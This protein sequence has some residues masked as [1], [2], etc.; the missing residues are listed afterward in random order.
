M[1]DHFRSDPPL[2]QTEA[3]TASTAAADTGH[4]D[5]DDGRRSG[6]PEPVR[7]KPLSVILAEVG[8]DPSRTHV[9]IMD[10]IAL[11]GGRGRA[12]LILLF[13]LPNVL[14]AP[15]GLSGLLGLPLVYL[16]VQMILGRAPWLPR[17]IGA[18]AMPRPRFA[19]LVARLGPWLGRAERLLRPRWQP[20]A[21]HMAERVVG[22]LILVLS[23]VLSL[24]VPLGNVLP[25]LAICLIALG[26]MERDGV[27][28]VA[29][30]V[31]G[32]GSLVLVAGIVYALAEAAVFL[33]INAFA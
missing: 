16:S 4:E 2:P 11:L 13:A 18:R 19:Q 33:L 32:I 23:A 10:L 25:A 8:E 5:D 17:F 9:A 14:P 31:V 27:W 12:A 22:L 3:E 15:P 30:T 26:I 24:P 20:L 7:R 21:G 28:V 1:Y 29:G 6:L